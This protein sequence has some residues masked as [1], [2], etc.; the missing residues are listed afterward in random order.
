MMY[1][2]IEIMPR[3]DSWFGEKGSIL[4]EIQGKF[5]KDSFYGFDM[6]DDEVGPG[7]CRALAIELKH[8]FEGIAAEADEQNDEIFLTKDLEHALRRF[9]VDPTKPAL[10]HLLEVS[11]TL[12]GPVE[13][14]QSLLR[15]IP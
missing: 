6:N 13:E 12:I 10:E 15:M 1:R 4:V 8:L 7:E 11:P 2:V 3:P 14:L 9:L 5:T